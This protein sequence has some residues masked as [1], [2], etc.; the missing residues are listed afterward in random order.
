[1]KQPG[2]VR[3]GIAEAELIRL[4]KELGIPVQDRTAGNPMAFDVGNDKVVREAKV[5]GISHWV[6]AQSVLVNAM[7]T[8]NPSSTIPSTTFSA[9][10]RN[11]GP[12]SNSTRESVIKGHNHNMLRLIAERK[13]VYERLAAIPSSANEN[14]II[15]I[16]FFGIS[17]KNKKKKHALAEALWQDIDLADESRLVIMQLFPELKQASNICLLEIPKKGMGSR[18]RAA[19]AAPAPLDS[20]LCA[21]SLLED[22]IRHHVSEVASTCMLH[23]PQL[24]LRL[25]RSR[26]RTEIGSQRQRRAAMS[27]RGLFAWEECRLEMMKS[28]IH[29][30][31]PRLIKTGSMRAV[32]LTSD[33]QTR[34]SMRASRR[35]STQ[36]MP[37]KS[38]R[39]LSAAVTMPDLLNGLFPR[40]SMSSTSQAVEEELAI[41]DSVRRRSMS[42]DTIHFI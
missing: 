26:G 16:N 13:Q 6:Y 3:Q 15:T 41:V 21:H 40:S 37:I 27:S 28:L 25:S 14:L 31:C 20:S 4:W 8:G 18:F 22:R 24:T 38:V 36:N 1:V 9:S 7:L 10:K 34:S 35:N 19:E 30:N 39:R 17:H 33:S 29:N 12:T 5:M 2:F 42:K 11:V 23:V 32:L